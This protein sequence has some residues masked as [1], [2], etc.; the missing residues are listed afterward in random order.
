MQ[1]YHFAFFPAREV[2]V[3]LDVYVDLKS[4]PGAEESFLDFVTYKHLGITRENFSQFHCF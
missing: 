3:R 2:R 1:Q 4:R